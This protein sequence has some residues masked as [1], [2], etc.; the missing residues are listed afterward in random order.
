MVTL[1]VVIL[2]VLEMEGVVMVGVK[3]AN[4]GML[5][6]AIAGE[7]LMLRFTHRM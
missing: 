4:E 3:S 5:F 2:E 6:A 7:R 1:A